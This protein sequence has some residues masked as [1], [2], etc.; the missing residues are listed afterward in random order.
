MSLLALVQQHSRVVHKEVIAGATTMWNELKDR[1][2]AE[3]TNILMGLCVNLKQLPGMLHVVA[4]T[5]LEA[6]FSCHGKYEHM[7]DAI[8]QRADTLIGS[9][10]KDAKEIFGGKTT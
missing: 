10:N 9:V 8:T 3:R 7:E 1:P 2:T 6:Y 4:S 5:F